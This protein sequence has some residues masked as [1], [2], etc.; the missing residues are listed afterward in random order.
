MKMSDALRGAAET[1]PVES[2]HVSIGAV[3]ARSQRNRALRMGANGVMG[4]GAAALVFAGVMGV[5]ANQTGL[6]AAENAGNKDSSVSGPTS[7]SEGDAGI[8]PLPNA[9]NTCGTTFDTS[10]FV[11]D[12]ATAS[13]TVNKVS[14]KALDVTINTTGAVDGEYATGEPTLYVLWEGIIVG[15]PAHND[16]GLTWN[17]VTGETTSTSYLPPLENCWDGAALPAGDYTIVSA[18]DIWAVPGEE[19]PAGEDPAPSTTPSPAVD[20][21]A[22]VSS[23]DGVRDAELANGTT[24]TIVSAPAAFT[25]GGD[26]AKDPFGRYLNVP[27][28]IVPTPVVPSDALTSEA[29]RAAYQAA[30]TDAQW[31]MA[32]GTHRVVQ[33]NDSNDVN[34]D[35]WATSYYGC[36]TEGAN[37]GF[38]AQSADLD[39]LQVNGSLPASVHVT[40]GWVVDGNPLLH[41]ATKNVSDWSLPGFY[42][43]S[44]PRLVLVKDGR[45]VAE[46]YPVNPDQNGGGGIAYPTD[47]GTG[48]S[49]GFLSSKLIAPSGDGY[50]AAGDTRSGDY[51]W[52]DI[53]GCWTST[54]MLTVEP[55]TYTVLTAQDIYLGGQ[56]GIMEDSAAASEGGAAVDVAPTPGGTNGDEAVE[57]IMAPAPDYPTDYVSFQVWTSLGTVTVTN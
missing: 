38:P 33:T 34:G 48:A 50:L 27:E 32:K 36:A 2:V 30:L 26:A 24:T 31:D 21:D 8:M 5:V 54:G 29:A 51:L 41:F 45:V 13:I 47:M 56:Y 1:A 14:D 17:S 23:D 11:V 12:P 40:Y 28:P 46:A 43:G 15:S 6:V 19:A 20:P 52:R 18:Q 53:N 22:S 3:K 35:M 44:S 57:P 25:I 7:A 37:S 49:D 10:A 4:V 42:E 39:W 55:G 16:I 9:A